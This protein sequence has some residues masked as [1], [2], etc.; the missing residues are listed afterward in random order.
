MQWIKKHWGWLASLGA[1]AVVFL[2]PSMQHYATVHPQ[3]SA[4]IGTLWS[5]AMVWAKSPRQ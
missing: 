5:V 4:V 2:D 3:Y 1:G